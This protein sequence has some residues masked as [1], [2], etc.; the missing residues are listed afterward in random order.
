M[1]L[2]FRKL[3]V[4]LMRPFWDETTYLMSS[5]VNKERLDAAIDNINRGK[6]FERELIDPNS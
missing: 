5:K 2:F 6:A 4:K 3:K 1:V